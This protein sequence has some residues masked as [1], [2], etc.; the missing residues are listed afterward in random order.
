MNTSSISKAHNKAGVCSVRVYAL[1]E[2]IKVPVT[3]TGGLLH[4]NEQ[5]IAQAWKRNNRN[6]ILPQ[7]KPV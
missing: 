3:T 6:L 2:T 1:R 4:D 7:L 5:I